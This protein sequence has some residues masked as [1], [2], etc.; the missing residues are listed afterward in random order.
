MSFVFVEPQMMAAF[1]AN[2]SGIGSALSAANATAAASTTGVL[3]AAADEVSAGIA[4][5]F[6]ENA[7]GYQQVSAQVAASYERFVQA[8][9]SG[10]NA[11]AAAELGT[12]QTLVNGLAAPALSV[13]GFAQGYANFAANVVNAEL[14]FN[15]A[16]VGGEVALRQLVFGSG[17]ALSAAVDSGLTV[18]NSFVGAGQTALN[19]LLGAQVPANFASSLV[20]DSSLD[21]N[22]GLGGLSGSFNAAINGLGAQLNAALSGN[23]SAALPDLNVLVQAGNA[24]AANVNA[25]INSL[26]QTGGALANNFVSNLNALTQ[27]GGSLSAIFGGDLSA[28]GAQ[29][30]GAVNAALSGNLGLGLPDLSALAQTGAVLAANFNNALA[31]FGVNFPALAANVS[32]ALNGLL[33][34][35]L[36]LG[37][38]LPPLPTLDSL[39]ANLTAGLNGLASNFNLNLPALAANINGALGPLGAQINAAFTGALNGDASGL[40]ALINAVAGLPTTGLAG[41]EQLQSGLLVD[42]TTNELALNA[43]LVANERALVSALLGAPAL[44]GPAGYFFNAGNLLLGTGEQFLNG[45][46]GAPAVNL[47]SSLLFNGALPLGGG[48]APVGGLTG[49][50]QQLLSLNTALGGVPGLDAALLTQLGLTPTALQAIANAQLAFNANLVANEQLLQLQLFGTGGAL[51]GAVN[52]AFNGLNLALVGTPQAVINALLGVPA[53]PI[54]PSLL[55]SATGDVF[56]GVTAGGLL[57][58]LEQKFLFDAAVLSN[59]FAPVQVTLTGGLPNLLTNL[60]AVLTGQVTVNAGANTGG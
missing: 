7:V 31:G 21:A 22:L 25:G 23:L 24:L 17:N 14:S 16:L 27:T 6:S 33:T 48:L 4:A 57:G 55:V 47:T 5:L 38:V 37:L 58:A 49:V 11:Y 29:I 32:T 40:N 19:T 35:N 34:G 52:N 46:V 56:G 13:E 9:T 42:L 39:A 2:L 60:N 1:A 12:A 59:L 53:V 20:V 3:A 10:A 26:V 8:V 15:Q 18:A 36:D 44:L 28:L 43:S 51:N 45:L 41:F 30:N 50:V 54:A